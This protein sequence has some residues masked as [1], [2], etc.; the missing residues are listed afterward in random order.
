VPKLEAAASLKQQIN[1]CRET[2]ERLECLL[3][4]D[5]EYYAADSSSSVPMD[6]KPPSEPVVKSVDKKQVSTEEPVEKEAELPFA[7]GD[8]NEPHEAREPLLHFDNDDDKA[9]SSR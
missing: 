6:T 9:R 1:T 7:N 8:G 3:V 2:Q 5:S 4:L